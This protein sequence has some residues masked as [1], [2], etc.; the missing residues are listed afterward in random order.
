M[1]IGDYRIFPGDHQEVE[2]LVGTLPTGTTVNIQAHVFRSSNPG[3]VALFLAGMH[4]DE[5]NGIEIVREAIFNGMFDDLIA[6]SVIAI[7]VLNIYGFMNFSRFVPDGKD[8]NRS[9]KGSANGSLASRVAY[10]LSENILP[11]VDF[12]V[13]FHTGGESRFN[14]PQIRYSKG[15]KIGKDLAELF[16]PPI[17]LEKPT[18]AK[19]LRAYAG[20]L[21]IPII[22]YEGGESLRLDGHSISTGVQGIRKLLLAKKMVDGNPFRNFEPQHYGRASWIRA[23][24]SGI[25]IWSKGAGRPVEKGDVLGHIYKVS[26]TEKTAVRASRSGYLIAHNNI[27]VV[28]VGDALFNLAY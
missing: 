25:F 20:S 14:F 2:F 6:G 26:G 22:V 7:P 12:G 1:Q 4:G 15:S 27:P 23:H 5:I 11:L 28:N 19:T 3:P 9:F 10:L 8:V 16:N 21:K 24:Q 18:I 13:D 17:I